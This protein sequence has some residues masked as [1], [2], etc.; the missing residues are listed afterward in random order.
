MP[1][2][3]IILSCISIKLRRTG[4]S[5][6]HI[7]GKIRRLPTKLRHLP[8]K[9]RR[10]C[11]N[12]W[13]SRGRKFG[14]YRN[15]WQ[16]RRKFLRVPGKKSEVSCK[17]FLITVSGQ[18]FR[19]CNRNSGVWAKTVLSGLR[20]H[21]WHNRSRDSKARRIPS[22]C[23]SCPSWLLSFD[24]FVL[25]ALSGERIATSVHEGHE[26]HEG[27]REQ[28]RPDFYRAPTSFSSFCL[29]RS[30]MMDSW[31]FAGTRR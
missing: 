6:R 13:Q 24:G 28:N 1:Y 4:G 8:R 22:S 10:V 27:T 17:F 19:R 21:R 15:R 14:L 29:R 7:P 11:G 25:N 20:R 26:E 31:T 3:S 16:V 5:T 18:R 2:P 23:S 30:L 9:E 12:R